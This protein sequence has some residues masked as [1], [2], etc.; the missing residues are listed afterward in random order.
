MSPSQKEVSCWY[1]VHDD[2]WIEK[3]GRGSALGWE[4][5]VVRPKKMCRGKPCWDRVLPG[6]LLGDC[7]LKQAGRLKAMVSTVP[8]KGNIVKTSKG[9]PCY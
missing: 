3:T 6:S 8:Q 2:K 9:Q 5:Q 4:M 7:P 1:D